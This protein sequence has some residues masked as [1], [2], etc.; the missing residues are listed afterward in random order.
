MAAWLKGE[1]LTACTFINIDDSLKFIEDGLVYRLPWALE[2]IRVRAL[3]NEDEIFDGITIDEYELGLVVPAIENGTLDRSVALLMQAGFNSRNAAIH[4]VSS[5]NATFTNSHQFNAWLGSDLVQE[6]TRSLIWPTPETS[7]LWLTFLK[8]YQP[9]SE[10]TWEP[11]SVRMKVEWLAGQNPD[12]RTVVKLLNGEVGS[13]QVIASDCEQIGHLNCRYN[14]LKSGVYSASL[15][16][17][18]G[19][20]DVVF[21]GAEKRPFNII[22][23]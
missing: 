2:A 5:T 1:N 13:T 8:E 7:K 3:A 22:T 23:T 12:V 14:L 6:N 17:D 10:T 9:T 18:I 4:A 21:W 11:V 16:E 20:L 19:Y 15:N